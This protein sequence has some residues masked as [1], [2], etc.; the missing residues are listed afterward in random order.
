MAVEKIDKKIL[1]RLLK[2]GRASVRDIS[3]YTGLSPQPV[4]YR[5]RSLGYNKEL[6]HNDI[7][8]SYNLILIVLN[9]DRV[10]N[11]ALNHL[12]SFMVGGS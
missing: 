10:W 5:I 7:V 9:H 11:L 2:G 1:L 6:L 4:S 8:Y 3:R 12:S